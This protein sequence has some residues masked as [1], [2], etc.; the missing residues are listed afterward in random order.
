[1]RERRGWQKGCF[2]GCRCFLDVKVERYFRGSRLFGW[3]GRKQRKIRR[4]EKRVLRERTGRE[5]ERVLRLESKKK[6]WRAVERIFAEGREEGRLLEELFEKDPEL[7]IHTR[8]SRE[9]QPK[10][11][12]WGRDFQVWLPWFSRMFFVLHTFPI[13]F[14]VILTLLVELFWL[15]DSFWLNIWG[16]CCVLC[17]A[18]VNILCFYFYFF[19]PPIVGPMDKMMKWVWHVCWRL[20]VFFFFFILWFPLFSSGRVCKA[21]RLGET[22]LKVTLAVYSK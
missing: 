12:S 4:E 20:H 21:E 17:S 13:S 6:T 1:M 10:T 8:R 16:A 18:F 11:P 5:K 22:G 7:S 14:S 15:G 9:L 3:G 2:L 19:N